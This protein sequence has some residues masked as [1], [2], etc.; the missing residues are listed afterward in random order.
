MEGGEKDLFPLLITQAGYDGNSLNSQFSAVHLRKVGD[1]V[2]SVG[3]LRPD[4]V[5]R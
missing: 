3:T 4:W 1:E 2:C 5:G